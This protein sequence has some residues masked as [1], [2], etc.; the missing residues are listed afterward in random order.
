MDKRVLLIVALLS[1]YSFNVLGQQFKPVDESGELEYEKA[2]KEYYIDPSQ[3][4]TMFNDYLDKYPDSRHRNRVES[5]IATAYFKEGRYK[6]AIAIF[7][8]CDIDALSDGERDEAAYSL[9]TSYLKENNVEKAKI[10]FTLLKSISGSHYYDALYNLAYIDYTEGRYE[11][12]A[13]S[14]LVLKDKDR[15]SENSSYYLSEIYLLQKRYSNSLEL[16][17]ELQ[18]RYPNSKLLSEY[19]RVEGESYYGMKSYADAATSL[20]KY[21]SSTSQPQRTAL[22]EAGISLYNTGIYS[23]AA[24][25][26]GKAATA[27][28]EMTQSSYYY[29]GLSY[30]QLKERNLA[31]MSFEQSANYNFSSKI[32]EE[33]LYNYAL[34]I[35]ETSYS[36]FSQSVTV[37]EKFLNEFPDSK[38]ADMVNDYLVEVYMN[39]KS[40]IAALESIE[41][42]KTPGK[43]ILEAKQKILF[44]LGT[45]EFANSNFDKALSY[46]NQSISLGVYNENVTKNAIYWKGETLYRLENYTQA[47]EAFRKYI[48]SATNKSN[49]EYKLALY[50]L[51]YCYFKLKN[52][53]QAKGWFERYA[54]LPKDNSLMLADAYNRIGDCNFYSRDFALAAKNY[55]QAKAIDSSLADY[56]L[57]QEAFVRGLQRDYSGK[58]VTLNT[59]LKDYPQSQYI[60]DALYEQGRAFVQMEQNENAIERYN[61]LLQKFPQSSLARKA[62]SEIGLLYYQDDK[63]TQAISAYKK[64]INEFPGSEEARQAQRDLKSIY[65]DLNRVDEY[66]AFASTANNGIAFDPNERDS[67]T[68]VAAEKVYMKGNVE[69]AKESFINY[70]QIFPKGAFALDANYY[71]GLI[72]YNQK[73]YGES[74]A[75]FDKVLQYPSNKFSEEAMLLSAI[76]SF[77]GGDFE[78]SYNIYSALIN[79]TASVEKMQRAQIGLLKSA[80]KLNKTNEIVLAANKL[81]ESAKLSPELS[82]EAKYY[83]AKAYMANDDLN[84]AIIDLKELAKDTR[85]IYGAEA[86]YQLAQIYFNQG[87]LNL[88]EKELLNYIDVSTPHVYWLA[89][90]FV[91]LSDIYLQTGREVEA[92]QYLLSLKQNYDENQEINSMIES[93]LSRL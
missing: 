35:H 18:N 55:S 82:N 12:A 92:K 57:Y 74:L 34:L 56:S 75:A 38:Y 31:R 77:E 84:T 90:S 63:F 48:N 30:L 54:S 86:K 36:P 42:I 11:E 4:I 52:Y 29:M 93:R 41:K 87:N 23:Q 10:W 3:S 78:K 45:Q 46:F 49:D 27:N 19:Y 53:G 70:I 83:R 14:F 16:A 22:Y 60:D 71:I 20:Q 40:Y 6:E 8:S 47:A 67:L 39:T 32:K 91:L 50:N 65:I 73:N 61:I 62:A 7:N 17:K 25:M 85:N 5:L 21:I 51:G 2:C 9:A 26:F 80:V 64:V 43:T 66:A 58:I 33:S 44:S 13:K 68:F 89:R 59:L 79:K 69:E 1:G 72:H 28:D 76:M 88:A 15:F 37:F 24:N 81:L